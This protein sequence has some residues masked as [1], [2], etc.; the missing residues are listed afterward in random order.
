M[1][2]A[3]ESSSVCIYRRKRTKMVCVL[4]DPSRRA[5]SHT[6]TLLCILQKT[7][8]DVMKRMMRVRTSVV[9]KGA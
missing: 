9:E 1:S 4:A 3:T 7:H 2:A 8:Q 5:H 6:H